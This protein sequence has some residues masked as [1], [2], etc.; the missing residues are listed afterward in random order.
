[1]CTADVL[2]VAGCSL[3]DTD[4]HLRALI[5]SVARQRKQ[6]GNRYKR[7]AI[8]GDIV[9]RRKWMKAL[10]ATFSQQ[11]GYKTFEG[12]LGQELHV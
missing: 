12:F 5:G 9:T 6:A 8:V 1:L 4:F 3:I 2:V 11:A 10:R 7:V